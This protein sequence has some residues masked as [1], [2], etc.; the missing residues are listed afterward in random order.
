MQVKIR[1][2]VDIKFPQHQKYSTHIIPIKVPSIIAE[3][4]E[5]RM[6]NDEPLLMDCMFEEEYNQVPIDPKDQ[7]KTAFATTWGVLMYQKMPFGL[8]NAPATFQ[9]LMS[10]AFK[11]Y[12]H[13]WLEIFL[14]DLCIYSRWVDHLKYL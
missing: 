3:M 6:S 11:E 13:V 2:P 8:T 12:L 1:M 4:N 5:D 14:D 7:L 10:I 9:R